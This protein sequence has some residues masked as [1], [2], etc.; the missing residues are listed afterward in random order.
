MPSARQP[1]GHLQCGKAAV[2][3]LPQCSSRRLQW[4]S[5]SAAQPGQAEREPAARVTRSFCPTQGQLATG[6]AQASFWA[7]ISSACED[8]SHTSNYQTHSPFTSH[9]S[10]LQFPL[11]RATAALEYRVLWCWIK[12]FHEHS[13]KWH[14]SPFFLC[15]PLPQIEPT[16][17]LFTYPC[18]QSGSEERKTEPSFLIQPVPK[19]EDFW[20]RPIT[21]A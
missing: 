11:L 6:T 20:P 5:D 12:L 10:Q 15:T 19:S 21:L 14:W 3:Q 16:F 13:H 1:Q 18:E 2:A 4:E 7:E 8:R 9:S 17:Y